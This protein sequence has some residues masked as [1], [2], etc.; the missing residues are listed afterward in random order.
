MQQ[1]KFVL[2]TL[3]LLSPPL[4]I[5][6][7]A[8]GLRKPIALDK[9]D[10]GDLFALDASGAVLRLKASGQTLAASGSFR[11]STL[12][13][14]AP[15]DLVSAKLFGQPTLLVTTNNQKSGFLS[16]YSV[17]G[18]L[19][20]TWTFRGLVVGL[21][22]DYNS[23]IVYVAAYNT[24]EIYGVN[25]Q[26][27]NAQAQQQRLGPV[28]VGSV[29]GARHLGPLAVDLTRSC[30]YLGDVETGQVFQFDIK[31]HKSRVIARHL[32]SPQA[33]LLSSDSSSLYIADALG[34]KV[35]ILDLTQANATPKIFSALAQFR[36]P[37]GLAKLEDGRVVV[38]DDQAGMI[39]ILSQKGTV[40]ST[41]AL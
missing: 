38:A 7:N 29:L 31:T 13:S 20:N 40:Q 33:L 22:V 35:Y 30:L 32:S 3:I 6:Q 17:D 28:F 10:G 39:F 25:L 23:H 12:V 27:S 19:Q 15:T 5:G 36:S 18:A 34:R 37:T 11:L 41:L 16:Q 21:D 9:I 4:T 1:L 14:S 8:T 26:A 2:L 24:P